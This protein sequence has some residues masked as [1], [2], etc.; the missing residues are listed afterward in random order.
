MQI[1]IALCAPLQS[2][3]IY[4]FSTPSL[5][6]GFIQ[7]GQTL[8]T[9]LEQRFSCIGCLKCQLQFNAYYNLALTEIL[10]LKMSVQYIIIYQDDIRRENPDICYPVSSPN[11]V[12][13]GGINYQLTHGQ[14]GAIS[15][16][17]RD[18]HSKIQIKY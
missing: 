9:N 2:Q 18:Q 13:S 4:S 10:I 16:W 7:S 6:Q 14:M 15:G 8:P 11:F 5:F 3:C 17:G 1:C 12:V